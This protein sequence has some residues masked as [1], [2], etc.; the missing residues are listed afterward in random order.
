[1]GTGHKGKDYLFW[2]ICMSLM[3]SSLS[4][5]LRAPD[6]REASSETFRTVALDGG[7]DLVDAGARF[8]EGDGDLL[9]LVHSIFVTT[10]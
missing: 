9:S 8:L 7:D 6:Q 2:A 4:S 10:Y 3:S 5:R 1:M